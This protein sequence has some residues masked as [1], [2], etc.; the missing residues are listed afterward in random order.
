MGFSVSTI[1]SDLTQDERADVMASFKEGRARV[2]IA[3]D[4]L[5]RGIDVQQVNL[6]INHDLPRDLASY[7]HRVGRSGRFGRKGA[8]ISLLAGNGDVRS[9]REIE[10]YYAADIQELPSDLSALD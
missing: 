3:T 7:I 6:V 10:Q 2:L 5:A 1:H 9:L 8:A 4:A